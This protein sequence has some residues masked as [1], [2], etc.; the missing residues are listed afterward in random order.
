MQSNGK[1]LCAFLK[2]D[3]KQF[4][5]LPPSSICPVLPYCREFCSF[6]GVLRVM[7]LTAM[8]TEISSSIFIAIDLGCLVFYY[9]VTVPATACLCCDST[10]GTGTNS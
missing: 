3:K 5:D 10:Q 2:G 4:I 1:A 9:K 6:V 8:V 7:P